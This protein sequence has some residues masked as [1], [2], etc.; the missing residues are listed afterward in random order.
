MK[1]V[2]LFLFVFCFAKAESQIKNE[3]PKKVNEIKKLLA[4]WNKSNSPGLVLAILDNNNLVYKDTFG[5]A[6][7]EYKE[8][9]T[10]N[11]IFNIGSVSK[12][13]TAIAIYMLEEKGI[14][15]LDEKVSSILGYLPDLYDEITINN[16]MN[17]TSGIRDWIVGLEIAGWRLDN[18]FE[19]RD[20]LQFMKN[21]KKLNFM[22]GERFSYSN[23][24]YNL[25]AEIVSK[26]TN[27][28]FQKWMKEN[29]FEALGMNSTLIPMHYGNII[30]KRTTGYESSSSGFNK[31]AYSSS[32]YGSGGIYSSLEDMIKWV[33]HLNNPTFFHKRIIEKMNTSG[34]AN[35]GIKLNYSG[36]QFIGHH[37]GKLYYYHAGNSGAYVSYVS[38]YPETGLSIILLS[39]SYD[40]L[41]PSRIGKKI[42]EI[43]MANDTDSNN[44]STVVTKND[45]D[46][47]LLKEM[48]GDYE[49]KN[50]D[51]LSIFSRRGKIYMRKSFQNTTA[52]KLENENSLTTENTQV[53]IIFTYKNS[54]IVGLRYIHKGTPKFLEKIESFS[55]DANELEA[56]TGTYFS[57]ELNT[58]YKVVKNKNQLYLVHPV[59]GTSLLKSKTCRFFI[60]NG[61]LGLKFMINKYGASSGFKMNTSR[62]HEIHFNKIIDKKTN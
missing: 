42:A 14:L 5:Y 12:Q 52:L 29:I 55:C 61:Y 47:V 27:M 22:P 37:L 46:P 30:P 40:L 3:K 9:I 38:R 4:K 16:L 8:K 43:Y 7:L 54:K 25:L 60:S 6:N 31:Y 45:H 62:V 59:N 48:S 2:V 51:V 19:M 41:P 53:K 21:Q 50:G 13:F 24:G 17:H 58:T 26:K 49:F 39:N 56:L 57:D 44:K 28:P 18:N 35:N 20:V 33:Q 36:G 32:T 23:S 1:Y 15:S 11:T 34:F 10:T